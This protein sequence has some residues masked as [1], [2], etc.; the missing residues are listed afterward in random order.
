MIG[1]FNYLKGR[2]LDLFRGDPEGQMRAG[3]WTRNALQMVSVPAVCQIKSVMTRRIF[4][5]S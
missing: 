2:G 3:E 1:D 5:F 4:H